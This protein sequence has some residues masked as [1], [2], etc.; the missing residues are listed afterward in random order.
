MIAVIAMEFAL[1]LRDHGT[2]KRGNNSL[3][4]YLTAVVLQNSILY[5]GGFWS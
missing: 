3:W 4:M 2:P 5:W 1:S